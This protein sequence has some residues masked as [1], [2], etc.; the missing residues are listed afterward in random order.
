MPEKN[1]SAYPEV[2]RPLTLLN[3]DFKLLARI[4]ANRIRPWIKTFSILVDVVE[5]KTITY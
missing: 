3:A 2:Y 4:I 1:S 5:S